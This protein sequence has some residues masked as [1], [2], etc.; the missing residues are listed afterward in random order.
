MPESGLCGLSRRFLC[1]SERSAGTGTVVT[2]SVGSWVRATLAFALV[3]AAI[4]EPSW[5]GR[6]LD[7]AAPALGVVALDEVDLPAGYQRTFALT[8]SQASVARRLGV[9]VP[10]RG[11]DYVALVRVWQGAETG[12]QVLEVVIDYG[13][14]GV[15]AEAL[16][17]EQRVN[18][19]RAATQ[20]QVPRLP[21]ARGYGLRLPDAAGR[22]TVFHLVTLRKGQFVFLLRTEPDSIRDTQLVRLLAERQAMKAP[23]GSSAEA[24]GPGRW[25]LGGILMGTIAGAT[26]TYLAGVWLVAWLRDPLRRNV[27][28]RVQRAPPPP[29]NVRAIDVTATARS[30][31]RR[32]TARGALQ[33]LGLYIALPALVPFLWPEAAG[34]AVVGLLVGLAAPRVLLRHSRHHERVRRF[35]LGPR[36]LLA[37]PLSVVA[38][39]LFASGLVLLLTSALMSA[40]NPTR[41]ELGGADPEVMQAVLFFLSIGFLVCGSALWVLARRIAA[42][43]ARSLLQR[44]ARKPL[45]YL[46]SFGDDDLRLRVAIA[47]RGGLVRWLSP[48]RFERF[49]EVVARHLTEVGPVIAVDRPGTR[50]P[51]LGAARESLPDAVWKEVV[52]ER[53]GETS[54]IVVSAAPRRVP[55]GLA[56]EL[57]RISENGLWGKTVLILPPVAEAE[58][59]ARWG[60]FANTLSSVGPTGDPLPADGGVVLLLRL[61]P[62]GTWT[63]VTSGRRDEGSYA[64]ALELAFRPVTGA[65]Q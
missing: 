20:F 65:E 1:P 18:S 60:D 21:H 11:A 16:C 19:G 4:P 41:E 53:M 36:L 47:E 64:A 8:G 58:L 26:G 62:D 40:T 56:W 6:A 61:S 59:Q 39:A 25:E 33:L 43:R 2:R 5:A 49:E 3:A 13:S 23:P 15:A 51:P 63:A 9:P 17:D 52:D 34:F 14:N 38:A 37:G 32:A 29:D 42:V 31:R 55:P 30:R 44:D 46:R 28:R 27:G 54:W 22:A 50:L 10:K 45:L 57:S 12:R 7:G 35:D 48:R 24:C